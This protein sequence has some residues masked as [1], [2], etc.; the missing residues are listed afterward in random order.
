MT[1]IGV[2]HCDY[3]FI[4]A[5]AVVQLVGAAVNGVDPGGTFLQKAVGE[6]SRRRADIKADQVFDCYTKSE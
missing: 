1:G 2:F 5:Q 4:T 3:P 6:T